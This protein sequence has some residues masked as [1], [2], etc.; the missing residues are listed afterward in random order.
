MKEQRPCK[1]PNFHHQKGKS[2]AANKVWTRRLK[3][4]GQAVE[5]EVDEVARGIASLAA[6]GDVGTARLLDGDSDCIAC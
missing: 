2:S 3:R 6:G 1:D 4:D 5:L